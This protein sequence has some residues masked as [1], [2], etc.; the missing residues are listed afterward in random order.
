MYVR[1]VLRG[2]LTLEVVV[3]G[4]GHVCLE[5]YFKMIGMWNSVCV[6]VVNGAVGIRFVEKSMECAEKN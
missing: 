2:S 1:D 4:S 5:G 6:C 3:S